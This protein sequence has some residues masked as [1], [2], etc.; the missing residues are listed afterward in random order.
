[1]LRAF[2]RK[3]TRLVRRYTDVIPPPTPPQYSKSRK[4][5]LIGL[6]GL[7]TAAN[8]Y[9]FL[10]LDKL[11]NEHP[12]DTFKIATLNVHYWQDNNAQNN[13]QKLAK[14]VNNLDVDVLALQEVEI[15]ANELVEF[16][17]LVNMPNVAFGAGD[18]SNF[19]QA[20]LS[21][22]DITHQ[23]NVLVEIPGVGPRGMLR[24]NIAHP[25]AI[26]HGLQFFNT[27]L[28]HILEPSRIAQLEEFQRKIIEPNRKENALEIVVGDFNSLTE[29]DY[30]PK[31]LQEMT[32][33]RSM[34]NWESPQY[35]VTTWMREKGYLDAYRLKN[36][37]LDLLCATS[38]V[39]TR[40][41]YIWMRGVLLNGWELESVEKIRAQPA[42][43]H[44][45]LVA[46]FKKTPTPPQ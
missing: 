34:S 44:D 12:K 38:R 31:Y 19:G 42:T 23:E 36:K 45:G 41:D 2:A 24:T 46:T 13:A 29:Q 15:N 37:D 17:K 10:H 3:T 28:D 11:Q 7:T 4:G 33:F 1:M 22:H 21:K 16:S 9:L 30:S 14:I 26:V 32:H 20:V 5:V 27:H 35:A 6:L 18:L 43:D 8:I 39:G 40:I 25:F